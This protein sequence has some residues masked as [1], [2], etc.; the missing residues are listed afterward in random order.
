[1]PD[2]IDQS[3]EITRRRFIAG[4]AMAGCAAFLAACGTKGAGT[5][6]P[7]AGPAT[8]GPTGTA[9]ATQ[10]VRATPSTELNWAN[11]CC[12]LDV[13]P[14]DDT[15]WKTLEDFQAANGTVVN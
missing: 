13:D 10:G 2:R 1:M 8:P 15:K 3:I 6:A 9:A 4:G 7:T 14:A 11:W 5:E 12:Y